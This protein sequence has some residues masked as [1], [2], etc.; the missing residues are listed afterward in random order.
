M[1][2]VMIATIAGV[3]LAFLMLM[4]GF[5]IPGVAAVPLGVS[6]ALLAWNLEDGSGQQ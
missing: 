1:V 3:A 4:D 6:M 5:W 2:L